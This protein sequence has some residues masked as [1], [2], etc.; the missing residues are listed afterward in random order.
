M[1]TTNPKRYRLL[2]FAL[3]AIVSLA[4]CVG[5]RQGVS[6]PTI[7]IVELNGEQNIVVSYTNQVEMLSLSNGALIKLTNAKTG[8]VYR[9][10]EGA[11]R[12]WVLSGHDN[13]NAQFYSSPIVLDADTF[14]IADYNGRLLEVDTATATVKRSIT[15]GSHILAD[16]LV[17]DGT[18]SYHSRQVV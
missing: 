1:N 2:I 7:G 8:E 3:L 12:T 16:I 9:T 10:T 4:G 13:D 5:S 14:L 6:W 15:V 11:P 17:V 18:M